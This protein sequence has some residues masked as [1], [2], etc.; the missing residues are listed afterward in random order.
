MIWTLDFQDHL[1]LILCVSI[2]NFIKRVG[3]QCRPRGDF[4]INSSEY[5]RV[6]ASESR[7][8]IL[9]ILVH[10]PS[11]GLSMRVSPLGGR[12]GEDGGLSNRISTSICLRILEMGNL[13]PLMCLPLPWSR[14]QVSKIR[15]RVGFGG[16]QGIVLLSL[17][18]QFR[19]SSYSGPA[20]N[21]VEIPQAVNHPLAVHQIAVIMMKC[22]F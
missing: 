16:F 22:H 1:T 15:S 19:S 20:L 14:C 2:L 9:L 10:S 12:I 17:S 11:C 3:K 18:C 7:Q 5:L 13:P 8:G 4:L 6:T 21:K